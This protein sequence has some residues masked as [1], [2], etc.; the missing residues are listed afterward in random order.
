[1]ILTKIPNAILLVVT[2]ASCLGNALLINFFS[3]KISSTSRGRQLYN[4]VASLVCA[5]FL[6]IYSAFKL[7]F[8]LYTLGVGAL[9][10]IVTAL[11]A[12]FSMSAMSIGPLSYT[13]VI[14]SCSTVITAL[15]GLFFGE[16]ISL[17][18]WI[19]IFLMGICLVFAGLK[20]KGDDEKGFSF[21]WLIL[22]LLAAF[23]SVGIGFLQKVHQKSSHSDELPLFL[24]IA[25]VFS[26]VF[27]A[28]F[29]AASLK[30]DPPLIANCGTASA[31]TKKLILISVCF[32]VAGIA[33][34]LNNIINLYLV[35]VMDSAVFFPLVNGGH[36]ILCTL[37]GLILFK[38][39]L[40]KIQYVGLVCG[41]A[42]TFCLCL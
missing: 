24:M 35:G 26:A 36:L 12:I 22:S 13:V 21:K 16:K 30:K 14:T 23:S 39:R 27:S 11:S 34:A 42:A 2:M 37:S 8:S 4:L 33:I 31:K 3:K 41:I 38:E 15:S 25:F 40:R 10:G 5:L 9:F 29:Y 20:T 7:K 32:A 1:M 17:L 19:G 18:K 28:T 6:L